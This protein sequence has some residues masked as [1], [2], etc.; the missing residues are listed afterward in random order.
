VSVKHGQKILV[1]RL[2]GPGADWVAFDPAGTQLARGPLASITPAGAEVQLLAP[3]PDVR[4][5]HVSVPSATSRQA[6]QAIPFALEDGIAG[7]LTELRL[8]IGERTSDESFP[9]GLISRRR[10]AGWFRDVSLNG[11]RI[12]AVW[13]EVLALPWSTGQLTL[14]GEGD[15]VHM[16]W[17]HTQGMTVDRSYADLA[18]HALVSQADVETFTEVLNVG[19]PV[20]TDWAA[21]GVAHAPPVLQ[22]NG[23]IGPLLCARISRDCPELD[24]AGNS[25]ATS[26]SWPALARVWRFSAIAAGL[27]I[28]L[29]FGALWTDTQRLRGE[30]DAWDARTRDA[31]QA[32]FPQARN[33]VDVERLMR[34]RLSEVNASG[35]RGDTPSV[36]PLLAGV[37]A[38]TATDPRLHVKSLSYQSGQLDVELTAPELS[39]FEAWRGRVANA[40][41][42][43]RTQTLN[44]VATPGGASAT[45]R[46]YR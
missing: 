16:R 20:P 37:G 44:A 21:I 31:Y 22:M 14:A 18:L 2:G 3:S 36:V 8:A 23:E 15:R 27:S 38:A 34:Q 12:A 6:M 45:L 29:L 46:V 40:G 41:S 42:R 25:A 39:H 5:S 17:G 7:E 26:V 19:T 10:L 33:V 35:T 13:P 30:R 9:V 24:M 43:L 11:A 28:A 32:A 4:L 1:R